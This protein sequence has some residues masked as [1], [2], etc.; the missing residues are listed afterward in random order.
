MVSKLRTADSLVQGSETVTNFLN[1]SSP[2]NRQLLNDV[3]HPLGEIGEGS[4]IGGLV[5]DL[6][7]YGAD[8]RPISDVDLVIKGSAGAVAEHARSVGAVPNKFGGYG[9]KTDAFK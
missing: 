6:A 9:L 5:R 7:F 3:L 1:S 8:E 2:S 4:V